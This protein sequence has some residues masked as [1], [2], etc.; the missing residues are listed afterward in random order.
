M[1]SSGDPT[2]FFCIS[3]LYGPYTPSFSSSSFQQFFPARVWFSLVL[4]SALPDLHPGQQQW[5]GRHLTF[6]SL[7]E[8]NACQ[9]N[10]ALNPI[11]STSRKFADIWSV[12]I[13]ELILT[14]L[15]RAT[16]LIKMYS[17]L[18]KTRRIFEFLKE[19]VP[20]NIFSL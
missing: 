14:G 13:F 17:L 1:S 20:D 7:H 18:P 11:S 19:E 15:A 10:P 9:W 3:G 16:S 2:L 6:L 4:L 8:D 12:I 5:Q